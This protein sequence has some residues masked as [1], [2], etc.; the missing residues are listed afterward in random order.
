M[1]AGKPTF[2][3]PGGTVGTSV[4]LTWVPYVHRREGRRECEAFKYGYTLSTWPWVV[5]HPRSW[6]QG[7]DRWGKSRYR[8]IGADRHPLPW[9]PRLRESHPELLS[10][11]NRS[12]TGSDVAV[13]PLNS[14]API[15]KDRTTGIE[16]KARRELRPLSS[17]NF[18]WTRGD[19]GWWAS[20]GKTTD[21]RG[22][23]SPEWPPAGEQRPGETVWLGKRP[24][25]PG[26]RDNPCMLN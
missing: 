5:A 8:T 12:P 17:V 1:G 19:S 2:P 26:R 15:T 18:S 20:A 23:G 13:H 25:Q 10:S 14:P 21:L 6:S 16:Y 11:V 3:Q 24:V 22:V 7:W 4:P 9:G